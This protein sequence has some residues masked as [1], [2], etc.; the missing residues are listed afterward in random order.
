MDA[1]DFILFILYIQL[2]FAAFCLSGYAPCHTGSACYKLSEKC[3]GIRQCVD[4]TDEQNCRKLNMKT[5][6]ILLNSIF[7]DVLV[8]PKNFVCKSLILLYTDM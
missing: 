5:K 7:K 3:D 6:S 1:I 2:F 8:C 4:G